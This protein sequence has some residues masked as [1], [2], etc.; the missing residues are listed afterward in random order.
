[1][2]VCDKDTCLKIELFCFA[3]ILWSHCPVTRLSVY[4]VNEGQLKAMEVRKK[5]NVF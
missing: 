4:L 3:N 2:Y 1:M 5:M